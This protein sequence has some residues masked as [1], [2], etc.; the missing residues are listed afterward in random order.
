M[1]GD[2]VIYLVIV[3]LERVWHLL[4]PLVERRMTAGHVFKIC[5]AQNNQIVAMHIA[6][7]LLV[8]AVKLVKV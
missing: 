6:S 4:S 2:A 8:L 3:K 7:R 1:Q 5:E